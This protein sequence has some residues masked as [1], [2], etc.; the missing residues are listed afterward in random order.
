MTKERVLKMKKTVS[1]E[2]LK[3][4]LR[5]K[6]DTIMKGIRDDPAEIADFL[7]FSARFR[8]YSFHNTRLLYAQKS[9]ARFI[10]PASAFRA[11]LPDKDGKP[12]SDKPIWI[13]K[14]ESALRVWCPTVRTCVVDPETNDWISVSHLSD[15]TREKAKT[16]NWERKE[17]HGFTLVPVFDIGQT[18]CPQE[19][20]PK[21]LG[22]GT[23]SPDAE[24]AFRAGCTYAR[25]VLQCEVVESEDL[26]SATV[27]GY[28]Q[29]ETNRIVLSY[30]LRGEGKTSTLY[31]EIGHAELH[32][33]PTASNL[34]TA[35]KELEADMY[36]LML[37][38]LAGVTTTDARKRHL[39][40]HYNA[41]LTQIKRELQEKGEALT[42]SS[43]SEPF[44]HVLDRY[45]EQ[46]PLLERFLAEAQDLQQQLSETPEVTPPTPVPTPTPDHG[47]AG[48]LSF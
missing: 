31:H 41:Y 11:G 43:D 33:D 13:K 28:F 15:E 6:V 20:Y 24:T 34:T 25:D 17:I 9:D 16:E 39:A 23:D 42:L 3:K 5:E 12:L 48:G 19:L 4:G 7:K 21:L 22:Y 47:N 32:R 1:Q 27:R 44:T 18:E 14:G 8:K 26:H 10:A 38:Q 36:A 40:S 29:P 35:Q 30:L 2:E 45:R 46:S 37:E